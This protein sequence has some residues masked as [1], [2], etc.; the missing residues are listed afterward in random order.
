MTLILLFCCR[1]LHNTG[2]SWKI[3]SGLR[4]G[5]TQVDNPQNHDSAHWSHPIDIHLAT[6]GLQGNMPLSTTFLG[7]IITK[8]YN[9]FHVVMFMLFKKH[10]R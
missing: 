6:K 2:G 5:Q 4:E 1:I 7:C 8:S 10:F 3:L 9:C